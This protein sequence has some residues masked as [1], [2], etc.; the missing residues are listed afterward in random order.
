MNEDLNIKLKLTVIPH[1]FFGVQQMDF[2]SRRLNKELGLLNIQSSKK[3][4]EGNIV[5]ITLLTKYDHKFIFDIPFGY[6]FKPPIIQRNDE[7]YQYVTFDPVLSNLYTKIHGKCPCTC[8]VFPFY[9]GNWSPVITL[10]NIFNYINS[11][12]KDWF[13]ISRT[14]IQELFPNIP[15]DIQ[16]RIAEYF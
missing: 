10:N 7:F 11:F 14:R 12:E 6:P 13:E 4:I 5:Q 3:D 9:N 1:F 8:C 2:R 15:S 16:S